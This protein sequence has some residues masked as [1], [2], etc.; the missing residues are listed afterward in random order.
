LYQY[1]IRR[2]LKEAELWEK[3]SKRSLRKYKI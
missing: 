3:L 1:N 2:A